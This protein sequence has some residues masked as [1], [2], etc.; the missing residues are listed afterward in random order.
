MGNTKSYLI[1]VASSDGVNIDQSFGAANGFTIY[2]VEGTDYYRKEFR[3]AEESSAGVNCGSG[4]GSEGSNKGCGSGSGCAG[5]GAANAK[6]DLI[7]D[8]RSLVCKKIGFQAQKALEKK[9]ISGFDIECTVNEALSK[10]SA[11]FEKLDNHR[12][13]RKQETK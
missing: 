5:G 9:A 8:C 12:S 6:V 10:I 2:E 1:A 3:Y 7:A 13:L 4:C 11:Y